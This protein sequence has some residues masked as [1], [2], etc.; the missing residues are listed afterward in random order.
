MRLGI[1]SYTFVWA[2]GVPGFLQ[3]GGRWRRRADREGDG[4]G[5]R[6]LQIADNYRWIGYRDEIER[7]ARRAAQCGMNWNRHCGIESANLKRYLALA[8]S[9]DRRS[10]ER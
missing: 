6:V 10:C 2:V 7:L 9:C 3:P 5:V 8:Q 1:S 4:I